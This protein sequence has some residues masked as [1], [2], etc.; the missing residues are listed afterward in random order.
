[1]DQ[2]HSSLIDLT[3]DIVTAYLSKN[4]IAAD[5]VPALIASVH[6]ALS[7]AGV[8]PVE[9]EEVVE[10]PSASQVRKSLGDDG[11]ISFVDGKTYKSLKRHLSRHGF[12]PESYRETFG[13]K[14]DYPMVAPAYSRARS[15]MAKAIGLGAKGRQGAPGNRKPRGVKA[16]G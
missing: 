12:T 2:Q 15:E 4:Q 11:L 8:E 1:M 3:V 6:S 14:S 9:P 5:Q 7:G 16:S 13:L 10:K